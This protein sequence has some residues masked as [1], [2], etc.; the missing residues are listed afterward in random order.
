DRQLDIVIRPP[1]PDVTI[2]GDAITLKQPIKFKSADSTKLEPKIQG[3]LD[4]VAE[5]LSDHPEIRT[6][7]VEA[8]WDASA[9]KKGKE[10]TDKQGGLVRDDRAKRGVPGGRVGAVGMGSDKPLVPNIGP[11]NKAKNRR[12][13]LHTTP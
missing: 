11:A 4:S 10:I 13:E 12:V 2:D 6:L 5:I 3:E 9:G 8:H 7:R 1:N